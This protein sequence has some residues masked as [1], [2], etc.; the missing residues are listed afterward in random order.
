MRVCVLLL[1]ALLCG[2]PA[3]GQDTVSR[4]AGRVVDAAT[5]RP[6]AGAGITLEALDSTQSPRLAV[7]NAEGDYAFLR[8]PPGRYRLRAELA[9]YRAREIEVQ[10]G[11]AAG[12]RVSVALEIEPIALE[13]VLVQA[14]SERSFDATRRDNEADWNGRVRRALERNRQERFLTSDVRTLTSADLREAAPLVEP[15]VLRALHRL[16]GVALRDEWSAELWTRGAPWLQTR[17]LWDGFPL[18]DP[19]HAFGLLGSLPAAAI[20]SVSFHPGLQPVGPVAGAAALLD[21]RSRPAGVDTRGELELSVASGRMAVE[22]RMLDG[23]L[24][25]TFAARRTWIDKFVELLDLDDGGMPFAFHD[26]ALRADVEAGSLGGFEAAWLEERDG[27][28]GDVPDVLEGTIA[29]R[30]NRVARLTWVLP[31]RSLDTRITAGGAW[32]RERID[33]LTLGPDEGFTAP[34]EPPRRLNLSHVRIDAEVM[35][36]A[37]VP[38]WSVGT[39]LL[40]EQL[41]YLGPA[42][43]LVAGHTPGERREQDASLTRLAVWGRRRFA[44]HETVQLELAGRA[45][46]MPSATGNTTL[47][48]APSLAVRWAPV[49][50]LLL[51]TGAARTFQTVQAIGP[52]GPW[53]DDALAHWGNAWVLAGKGAPVLRADIATAGMELWLDDAWLA[54]AT[55]WLRRSAGIAQPDPQPGFA[56]G[57]ADFVRARNRARG[58]ELGLRRLVGRWTGSVAWTWTRSRDRA[59]GL[60]VPAA[61]SRPHVLDITLGYTTGPGLHLGAAFTAASGAVYRRALTG[62]LACTGVP[63]C[64]PATALHVETAGTRRGPAYRSLDLTLDWAGRTFGLNT[65]L[66]LQLR[67]ALGASNPA[68]YRATTLDCDFSC[69]PGQPGPVHD[70]FSP[71]VPRLPLIGFRVTF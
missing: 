3:A 22:H 41:R 61:A 19:L 32:F 52:R 29:R 24:G 48:L 40:R 5:G 11:Q 49:P 58:V 57:R 2:A 10:V 15:D 31:G 71:G 55:A 45:E 51:S 17:V 53:I 59:A 34:R 46:T 18:Y 38:A 7:A 54:S 39:A 35:P 16:P 21:V 20:G 14:N 50:S 8:I 56:T 47:R 42:P 66:L 63:G 69:E 25:L 36:K 43:P 1:A 67:N 33:T 12:A 37:R 13:P 64:D 70:E 4:L 68:A 62:E 9:G 60:E 27:I 23:R 65:A 30:G 28:A 44:P 26:L 6:L